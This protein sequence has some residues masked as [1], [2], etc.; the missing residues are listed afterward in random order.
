MGKVA[1]RYAAEGEIFFSGIFRAAGRGTERMQSPCPRVGQEACGFAGP[2]LR[3]GRGVAASLWGDGVRLAACPD[4][5]P[6]AGIP[7]S[8]PEPSA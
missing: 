2:A 3:A 8:S 4:P 7:M 6:Q 5:S 1:R